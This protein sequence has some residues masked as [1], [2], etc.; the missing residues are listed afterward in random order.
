MFAVKNSMNRSPAFLPAA[1]TTEGTAA[2]PLA[3]KLS[4]VFATSS[5]AMFRI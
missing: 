3:V 4:S 1:M 2:E 5:P